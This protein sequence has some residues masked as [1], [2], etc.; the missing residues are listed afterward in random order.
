VLIAAGAHHLP[1]PELVLGLDP[2]IQAKSDASGTMIG[3]V[4]AGGEKSDATHFEVL[5]A[6]GLDIMPRAVIADKGYSSKANLTAARA[7]GIA[8]VIP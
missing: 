3:F 5:L 7:R 2:G 8:P 6:T 1:N 4:L